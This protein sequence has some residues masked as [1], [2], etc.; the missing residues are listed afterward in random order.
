MKFLVFPATKKGSIIKG[1][2][3]TICSSKAQAAQEATIMALN[4]GLNGVK[5]HHMVIKKQ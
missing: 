3:P 2:C 4:Y 1:F 5:F